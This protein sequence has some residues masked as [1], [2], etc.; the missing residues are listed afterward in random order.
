MAIVLLCICVVPILL[1]QGTESPVVKSSCIHVAHE[2]GRYSL[3]YFGHPC[4]HV[5]YAVLPPTL[6]DTLAAWTLNSTH[7]KTLSRLDAFAINARL[8]SL[9]SEFREDSRRNRSQ[10]C[11]VAIQP[12][13]MD[14]SEPGWP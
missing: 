12:L 1:A 13:Q 10:H 8:A 2:S 4:P 9:E 11:A 7:A 6:Y 3:S 14:R 5:D